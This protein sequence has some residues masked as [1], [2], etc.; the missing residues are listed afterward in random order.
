MP[1][2]TVEIFLNLPLI[3]FDIIIRAASLSNSFIISLKEFSLY[4]FD[5]KTDDA[6]QAEKTYGSTD[7]GNS[8]NDRDLRTHG[9]VSSPSPC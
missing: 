1:V 5:N 4:W 7:T 6:I 2:I 8:D 9:Y 3:C